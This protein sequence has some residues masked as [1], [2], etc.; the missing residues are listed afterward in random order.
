MGDS[1]KVPF[2]DLPIPL[3]SDVARIDSNSLL[4]NHRRGYI[5]RF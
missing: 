3:L 5:K 4:D 2:P 1:V